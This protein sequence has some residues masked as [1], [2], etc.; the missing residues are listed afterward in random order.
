MILMVILMPSVMVIHDSDTDV[1]G[2]GDVAD[3]Q[4]PQALRQPV[5]EE[6]VQDPEAAL[7]RRPPTS[8][9]EMS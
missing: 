5:Q 8:I 2:D 7:G 9:S 1:D 3:L 4:P 6:P